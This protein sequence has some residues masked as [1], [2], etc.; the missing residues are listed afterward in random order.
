MF[1]GTRR[2]S[3]H[4]PFPPAGRLFASRG[5]TRN[6]HPFSALAAQAAASLRASA[7]IVGAP[8]TNEK[9]R[10]AGKEEHAWP[11]VPPPPPLFFYDD[12]KRARESKHSMHEY[13]VVC[14]EKPLK[15]FP[16]FRSR[17]LFLCVLR[18]R[19][20]PPRWPPLTSMSSTGRDGGRRAGRRVREWAVGDSAQPVDDVGAVGAVGSGRRPPGAKPRQARAW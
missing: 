2:S 12:E 7:R 18:Q 6:P 19:R 16:L 15:T 9:E 10:G 13:L 17:S 14:C 4:L 1:R 11:P 20:V 8:Q 3:S 5:S